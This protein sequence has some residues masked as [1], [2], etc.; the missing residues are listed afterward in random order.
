MSDIVERLRYWCTT[1]EGALV[2]DQRL[3]GKTAV[4]AL[5]AD[6]NEA[7]DEIERLR[8]ELRVSDA[9]GRS[10]QATVERLLE[11]KT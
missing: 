4:E 1:K 7:A 11:E 5:R 10:M 6:V 8:R 3:R 2:P 9:A